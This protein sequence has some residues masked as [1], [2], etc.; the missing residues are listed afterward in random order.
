M[1]SKPNNASSGWWEVRFIVAHSQEQIPNWHIDAL[2]AHETL[3]PIL[4]KTRDSILFWR[5][6]RVYHSEEGGHQFNLKFFCDK[7]IAGDIYE[8][9]KRDKTIKALINTDRV[10]KI[11]YTSRRKIN[12]NISGT[13]DQNWD[14]SIQESWPHYA[15]GLSEMWLQLIELIKPHAQQEE[16]AEGISSLIGKY[17]AIHNHLLGLWQNNGGHAV[18]H[19][20]HS[21]MGWV[22]VHVQS[23]HIEGVMVF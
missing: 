20:S 5:I 8:A 9:I 11:T 3:K 12:A 22:P 1:Q 19:M 13:S 6:H 14:S 10:I 21:I 4:I 7:N 23:R 16:S 15:M 18:M 17:E 2:I